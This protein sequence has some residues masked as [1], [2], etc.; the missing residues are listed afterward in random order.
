MRVA[1]CWSYTAKAIL[2]KAVMCSWNAPQ[3]SH[4]GSQVEMSAKCLL[5]NAVALLSGSIYFVLLRLRIMDPQ[6]YNLMFCAHTFYFILRWSQVPCFQ[7]FSSFQLVF[8]LSTPVT[9]WSLSCCAWPK[10]EP[11]GNSW[12][13]RDELITPLPPPSLFMFGSPFMISTVCEKSEYSS[14]YRNLTVSPH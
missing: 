9:R 4:P 8:S 2:I 5:N 13:K 14:P 12:K 10:G 3:V 1:G 11:Q 7:V 6:L